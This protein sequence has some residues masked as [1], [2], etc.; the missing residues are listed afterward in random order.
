LENVKC[1]EKREGK[2]H[3]KM[4]KKEKREKGVC[5]VISNTEHTG[6]HTPYNTPTT[7]HF[8]RQQTNLQA[9]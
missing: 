3:G 7:M 2:A 5:V 9:K 6:S 4:E 1:L 8:I